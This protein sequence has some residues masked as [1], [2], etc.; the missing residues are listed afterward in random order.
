MTTN[1][2]KRISSRLRSFGAYLHPALHAA[3]LTIFAFVGVVGSVAFLVLVPQGSEILLEFDHKTLLGAGDEAFAL[4]QLAALVISVV[5]LGLAAWYTS[6]LV[7]DVSFDSTRSTSPK[8]TEFAKW[9]STWW[10]R[11][12]GAAAVLPIAF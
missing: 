11:V 8:A 4:P 9:L 1:T 7:L 5:A 10:P 12:L 2:W 3:S 6:R